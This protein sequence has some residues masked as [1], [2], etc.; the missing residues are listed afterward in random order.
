[1]PILHKNITASGDIHNPKWHPDANNGDYAWKNEKGELESIDELLLP[2]ALNFV[3]GSV[4]PPTS[5]TNDIYILSSGASV[6]AGWGTVSLQDWVKYDGAVWNVITPQKSSLCYDKTADSLMNFNGTS[7]ASIGGGG[8]TDANAVHVNVQSEISA[9]TAKSTPTTS[10]I[11]LI[12]DAAD[13]NNK[14]KITI[15]DLP[16][17]GSS[18][19]KFGIT[20]ANGEYSYYTTI[21]LA[22]SAASSGDVIEQFADVSVSTNTTL[23]FD[24]DITWNMNG[25]TY[26]NTS[27]VGATFTMIQISNTAVELIINNGQIIRNTGS[28]N[29]GILIDTGNTASNKLYLNGV[30]INNVEGQSL[31]GKCEIFGGVF[32]SSLNVANQNG[33]FYEGI[34]NSVKVY[35]ARNNRLAG[36]ACKVYDS[37]FF[38]TSGYTFLSGGAKCYTSIFESTGFYGVRMG[39]DD[40]LNNC[41]ANAT[42]AAGILMTGGIITNCTGL[43]SGGYGIELGG[44]TGSKAYNCVGSSSSSSGIAVNSANEAYNCTALSTAARAVFI[45]SDGKFKNGTSICS[46]NNVNGHG[47]YVNAIPAGSGFEIVGCEIIT[48]NAGANAIDGSAN[49]Q[50][51]YA[52]NSYKGMTTAIGLITSNLATNSTDNQGNLLL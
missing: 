39:L 1:M 21:Q 52:Q 32:R 33:L 36:T 44:N 29:Y 41:Y 46:F 25:Y 7:W 30:I 11:L 50:G 20:N 49:A 42:N 51:K 4:A 17:G 6:N 26:K 24:K 40:E 37:F 2:A 38:S 13:S 5:N 34:L 8:G 47:F 45:G 48:V 27:S 14:K 23:T 22:L 9:I 19:G 12:E 3:D 16:S 18:F 43:S 15:G 10:D 31:N 35:S 28:T